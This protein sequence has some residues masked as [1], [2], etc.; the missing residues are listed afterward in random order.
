MMM[1]ADFF[2]WA[3]RSGQKYELVEGVPMMMT[4][5]TD[6]H[7]IIMVNCYD[8]IRPQLDR[9]TW[10]VATE[11]G[12]QTSST[13]VRYPDLMIFPKG[14]D[15]TRRAVSDPAIVIEILS[16]STTTVDFEKVEEYMRL[17]SL[18]A[19][20]IL[21]QKVAKAWVWTRPY[22]SEPA[23]EAGREVTLVLPMG[24]K[25]PLLEAFRDVLYFE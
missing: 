2:E 15:L 13:T 14:R 1:T 23:E 17:Q 12:L 18:Q 24:I 8:I 22:P 25:L 16:T 9:R 3:E 11:F 5:S 4:G 21:S 19:Y 20:V 7:A 10:R 6:A